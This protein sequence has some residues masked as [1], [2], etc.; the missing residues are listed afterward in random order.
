MSLYKYLSV[1]LI[2]IW[3]VSFCMEVFWGNSVRFEGTK[4]RFMKNSM[5]GFQFFASTS[6][7][8]DMIRQMMGYTK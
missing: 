4:A 7:R 2:N 1:S 6:S 8:G 3:S 5:S